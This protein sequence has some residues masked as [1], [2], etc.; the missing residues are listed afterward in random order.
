MANIGYAKGYA[1]GDCV[2][3][4]RKGKELKDPDTGEVLRVTSEFVCSGRI[5]HIDEKTADIQFTTTGSSAP[6]EGNI[7][8]YVPPVNK[9]AGPVTPSSVTR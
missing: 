2:E 6:A 3:L 7:V 5:I 4:R 1:I 8:R 9:A